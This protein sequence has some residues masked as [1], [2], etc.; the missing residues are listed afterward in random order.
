MK[1]R[2][3]FFDFVPAFVIMGAVAIGA[4]WLFRQIGYEDL[5]RFIFVMGYCALG[6]CVRYFYDLIVGTRFVTGKWN[7]CGSFV[8]GIYLCH[9]VFTRAVSMIYPKLLLIMP[10]LLAVCVETILAFSASLILVQLTKKRFPWMW[11]LNR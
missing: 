11:G 2:S 7:W 1:L 8:M 10:Q 4:I 3:R 9:F 5:R 6:Y